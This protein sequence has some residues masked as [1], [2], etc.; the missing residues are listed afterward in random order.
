MHIRMR[1]TD[2]TFDWNRMRAF[3][4]T[5][6]TGS[7]SAAARALNLTQPTLGRQVAA[8][9]NELGITLFERVGRAL[10]ITEAGANLLPHARQMSEAASRLSL[11]AS[12]H[13]QE[14]SGT[15]RITASDV[16]S[17]HLLP[18]IMLELR[19]RAPNLHVDLIATNDIADLL[20]RE[21]DIA[22]RHVRPEQ[23]DLFAR[24]IAEA[25]GNF[26]AARS[27]LD[28]RGTPTSKEDLKHHDFVSFGDTKRMAE[29]LDNI[30]IHTSTDNYVAG[31]ENG[32]VAWELA[33]KGFGIAPMS[34]HVGNAFPDMVHV[35]PDIQ[36]IRFPVWLVTHREVH[37]SKRIRLVFDL[38]AEKLKV[39]S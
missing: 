19:Q 32:L 23:P 6:D 16:F 26:Y 39:L 29:Y 7:L 10:Q 22:I 25:K 36:P 33:R 18:D 13:S 2:Q 11:I 31:S 12:G 24:L 15:V 35:L 34:D 5:A 21:A 8:L 3:V 37:T 20:R 14:I 28:Q 30:G 1:H 9:E 27:Y 38:L 4:V 17:V